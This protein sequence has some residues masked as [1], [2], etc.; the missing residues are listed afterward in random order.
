MLSYERG[1]LHAATAVNL[2]VSPMEAL[3]LMILPFVFPR[4]VKVFI[5]VICVV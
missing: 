1:L 2:G 4:E 5:T 3:E